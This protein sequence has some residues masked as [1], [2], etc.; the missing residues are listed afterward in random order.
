MSKA[1][2]FVFTKISESYLEL[3]EP[4]TLPGPQ[5]FFKLAESYFFHLETPQIGIS[6]SLINDSWKWCCS[7]PSKDVASPFG[8]LF[9]QSSKTW[10]ISIITGLAVYC[11]ENLKPS[12]HFHFADE[13][14]WV[15]ET[16]TSSESQTMSLLR[17]GMYCRITRVTWQITCGGSLLQTYRSQDG[18][19]GLHQKLGSCT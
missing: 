18:D 8:L 10:G 14:S 16:V 13:I 4:L 12:Y 19:S 7:D 2:Y 17:F 11:L 9:L 15:S 1:I 3:N 6:G 5:I